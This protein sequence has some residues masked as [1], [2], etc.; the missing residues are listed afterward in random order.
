MKND[1]AV[2]Y[3]YYHKKKRER[4]NPF[5]TV[6]NPGFP[7][8]EATDVW[9]VWRQSNDENVLKFYKWQ[10]CIKLR[11]IYSLPNLIAFMK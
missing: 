4:I 3:M 1:N 8:R 7:Y 5:L 6:K 10:M 9:G 2:G 11:N